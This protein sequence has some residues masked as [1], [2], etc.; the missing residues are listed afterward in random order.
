MVTEHK[1][2]I[3]EVCLI[4]VCV[5]VHVCVF[6][7]SVNRM[8]SA[9]A[10][11]VGNKSTA[12]CVDVAITLIAK[13]GSKTTT[14]IVFSSPCFSLLSLFNSLFCFLFFFLD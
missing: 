2:A 12:K 10:F 8:E 11:C 7:L 1:R 14:Y 4:S 3:V 9:E 13:R 6:E 5:C